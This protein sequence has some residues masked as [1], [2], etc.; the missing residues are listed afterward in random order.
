MP[1]NYRGILKINL[2]KTVM[3]CCL[4]IAVINTDTHQGQARVQE[5]FVLTLRGKLSVSTEA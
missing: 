3:E 2:I 5:E 1:L 4:A